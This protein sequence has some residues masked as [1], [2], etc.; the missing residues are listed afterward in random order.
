MK[1]SALRERNFELY[2]LVN[3]M[4]YMGGDVT[5]VESIYRRVAAME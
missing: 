5:P 1:V 2:I 4:F 3:A